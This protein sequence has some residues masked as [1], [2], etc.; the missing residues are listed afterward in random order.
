L[1]NLRKQNKYLSDLVT[2]KFG[3]SI[4]P[5]LASMGDIVIEGSGYEENM[6]ICVESGW[7]MFQKEKGLQHIQTKYC[8]YAWRC[9]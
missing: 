4:Q 7:A 3:K 1:Y 9:K 5:E 8:T 2:E 6:G